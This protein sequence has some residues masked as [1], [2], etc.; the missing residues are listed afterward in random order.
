MN[1]REDWLARQQRMVKCPQHGLHFDPEMS[2][3]CVRCLKERAKIRQK[4][5]PQMLIILLCILGIAVAGYR[6]LGPRLSSQEEAL[7]GLEITEAAADRKLDPADFRQAIESFEAALF[8]A[9]ATS[10]S[11]LEATQNR[12]IATADI[13]REA[14]QKQDARAIATREVVALAGDVDGLDLNFIELEKLRDRWLRLRRRHLLAAD[15]LH[16]SASSGPPQAAEKRA[17]VAEYR[18]IAYEL[19]DLLRDGSSEVAGLAGQEDRGQ[20]WQDLAE[21]LNESLRDITKRKPSR[22]RSDADDRLLVA[23]QNLERAFG[24][25]RSLGAS[26]SAP[27]DASRFDEALRIAEDAIQ[28]FSEAGQ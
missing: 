11:D 14:L 20:A 26:S 9:E 24:M 12:I 7:E 17:S 6:I 3:G 5:P 1:P 21:H 22:P 10:R 15:W 23:F 25:A 28:G 27:S 13:L 18:D 4:R 19:A 8:N 16:A 2:T